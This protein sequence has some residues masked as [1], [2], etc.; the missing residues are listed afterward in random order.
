[1]AKRIR[2]ISV[3]NLKEEPND[4]PGDDFETGW[5]LKDNN[6]PE[7]LYIG[8]YSTK[9]ELEESEDKEGLK[10]FWRHEN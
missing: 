3:V 7:I 8:P 2:R 5:Y 6:N 1:M 9:R 4:W 10:R